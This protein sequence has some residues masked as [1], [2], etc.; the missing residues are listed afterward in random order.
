[1]S[2]IIIDDGRDTWE[3]EGNKAIQDNLK[4]VLQGKFFSATF[5]K[6]N[7]EKRHLVG[8][9]GVSKFV[10][11]TGKAKPDN[12]VTV[13]VPELKQYRSFDVARLGSIKC[14]STEIV[15]DGVV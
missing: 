4:A 9:L 5:N 11:G 13:Y 7:G 12:I 8:R 2:K 10:K 3:V 14:G 6:L 1:M 15:G